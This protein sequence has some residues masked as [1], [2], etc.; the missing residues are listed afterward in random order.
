MDIG[1][2][3]FVYVIDGY[4]NGIIKEKIADGRYIVELYDG[5]NVIV[6]EDKLMA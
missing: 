6:T 3:I 1:Q 4:R 5:S 2:R